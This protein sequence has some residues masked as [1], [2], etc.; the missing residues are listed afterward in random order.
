MGCVGDMMRCRC[1]LLGVC[2]LVWHSAVGGFCGF[3][4]VECLGGLLFAA[5]F[6]VC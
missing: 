1:S 2:E 5:R 3:V 4:Y 6:G